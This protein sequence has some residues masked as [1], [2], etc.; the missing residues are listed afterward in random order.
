MARIIISGL[1]AAG[2]TTHTALLADELRY[3]RL[4][5]T[6]LLLQELD[7]GQGSSVGVWFHRMAEIESLRDGGDA[8]DRVDNILRES[9]LRH[10]DLVVDAWAL[11]WYSSGEAIRIWIGSDRLSR[12]WKCAVSSPAERSMSQVECVRLIDEKDDL[13]RRRFLGRYG[14]DLYSDRSPFDFVL[15]NSHL[16][17]E[18]SR[19]SADLGISRFHK[20][21]VACAQAAMSGCFDPLQKILDDPDPALGACLVGLGATYADLWAGDL[22][23]ASRCIVPSRH[24]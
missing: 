11:P 4:H 14:F 19:S 17:A 10:D 23:S 16:I 8:D 18:P 7:G 21:V 6:D 22:T 3:D 15:D 2:K 9:M 1:T 12:A 24:L 5:I 13:S 20:V